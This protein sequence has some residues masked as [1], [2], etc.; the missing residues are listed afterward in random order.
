MNF[1]IN[2]NRCKHFLFLFDS[3]NS[4]R[5][6]SSKIIAYQQKYQIPSQASMDW[7]SKK[8]VLICNWRRWFE[9]RSERGVTDCLGVPVLAQTLPEALVGCVG[10]LRV[11]SCGLKKIRMKNIFSSWRNLILKKKSDFF[12]KN[13]KIFNRDKYFCS[14][15]AKM[16]NKT[17]QTK[18]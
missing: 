11:C 1:S 6:R 9:N 10:K 17:Q 5:Y 8:N 2:W 3:K 13:L 18:C 16:W 12:P 7:E 14:C 15:A 4:W